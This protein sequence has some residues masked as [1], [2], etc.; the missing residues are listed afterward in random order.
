M[1]KSINVFR[2]ILCSP[3]ILERVF[4][5]FSGVQPEKQAP[6]KDGRGCKD[7]ILSVS[8]AI[9]LNAWELKTQPGRQWPLIPMPQ[10][11]RV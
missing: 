6:D 7:V 9:Y 3:T 8:T 2:N 1:R 10:G 4:A 11:A 5:C